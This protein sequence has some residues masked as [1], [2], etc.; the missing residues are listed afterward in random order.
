MASRF[1]I[2]A[3]FSAVDAM[4]APMNKM[5]AGVNRFSNKTKSSMFSM[6][7]VMS[8]VGLIGGAGLVIAGIK[9]IVSETSK[10]ENAVANFTP[11]LGGVDAAT[12]AVERMNEMAAKTPFRFED[13]TKSVQT[14]LPAMNGDMEKTLAITKMLGD[15]A[16]GNAQKMES[17]TRGF[18]KAQLKG[19]VDMESLNMIGEAGVP[20]V[21]ALAKSMGYGKGEMQ[22]FF[23][24]ISGGGV[25][26]EQLTKTFQEMTSEGGMYYNAMSIAAGTLSGKFSTFMDN[27][28]LTGA[29]IGQQFL[30]YMQ[31]AMDSF[32]SMTDA[33]RS[34]VTNNKELIKSVIGVLIPAIT[35]LLKL[36]IA[37]K[38]YT[39]AVIIAQNVMM[40]LGWLSYLYM[41][42]QSILKAVLVTG[43]WSKAQAVI[44][45]LLTMNPIGLVVIAIAALS[46]AIYDL[47]TNWG[48]Y[49]LS[50]NISIQNF[51]TGFARAKMEVYELLNAIGLISD[52]ELTGAKL[53]FL[54]NFTAGVKMKTEQI[55]QNKEKG[56]TSPIDNAPITQRDSIN[57][58]I[59]QNTSENNLNIRNDSKNNVDLNGQSIPQGHKR[60]LA[61]SGGY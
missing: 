2:E 6:S 4:T 19:K 53:N 14:L 54:E 3:V 5:S 24:V 56:N 49:A 50:F 55:K 10:M 38:I 31:S 41:M 13:I 8:T 51:V 7:N 27:V 16:G 34:F 26:T 21:T 42:R 25:S 23:K 47:Y 18:A 35:A 1:S 39:W 45:F 32:M 61:P 28:A 17:I 40:G 59:T 36:Y 44:N 60:K 20:I 43:Q 9:G 33:V 30:P 22:K 58:S 48:S 12:A 37:W 11:I 52:K 57:Q 29:V 15:T 46:Y